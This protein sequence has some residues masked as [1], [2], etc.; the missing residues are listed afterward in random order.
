MSLVMVDRPKLKPFVRD[1]QTIQ[2]LAESCCRQL[3][4]W[5]GSISNFDFEGQRRSVQTKEIKERERKA[6]DFRQ[7]FL[8]KL[9]PEHPLYK[10]E[11]AREARGEAS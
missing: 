5:G 9:T 8:R 6:R 4:G 3:G 10:S 11:E 2:R 7:N 1:L